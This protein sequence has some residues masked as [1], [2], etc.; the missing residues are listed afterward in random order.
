MRWGGVGGGLWGSFGG[1]L[2][3]VVVFWVS[4]FLSFGGAFFGEG[5]EE[6]NIGMMG[7]G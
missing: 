6:G 1:G 7:D 4:E 3:W 2:W 5:R